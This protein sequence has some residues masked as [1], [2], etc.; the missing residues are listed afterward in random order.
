MNES[1]HLWRQ[2]DRRLLALRLQE[3]KRKFIESM[4][5]DLRNAIKGSR[6]EQ[7]PLLSTLV[8]MN[9]M[10]A[11]AED[12]Y[13]IYREIWKKQG[14][15]ESPEFIRTLYQMVIVP[16]ID[17]HL[18]TM[19]G[20]FEKYCQ[21]NFPTADEMKTRLKLAADWAAKLKDEWARKCE[22][23]ALELE[24]K[25][26]EKQAQRDAGLESQTG[27]AVVETQPTRPGRKPLETVRRRREIVCKMMPSKKNF[28]DDEQL[29]NLFSTLDEEGIPLPNSPGAPRG[30][31]PKDWV[32]LLNH[33]ASKE[34]KRKVDLLIRDRFPKRKNT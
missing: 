22:I 23:K 16:R 31:K 27:K 4:A 34:T 24:H 20:T 28:D 12:A 21:P 2:I 18:K 19:Q 3:S 17:R 32:E 33:P 10:D 11:Q 6:K 25:K 29:K 26:S 5:Q 7:Y 8:W 30:W 9:Q 1:D 14:K 15:K 13:R